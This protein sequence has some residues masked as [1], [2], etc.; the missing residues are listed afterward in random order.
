MDSKKVKTPRVVN[1]VDGGYSPKGEDKLVKVI[2][3]GHTPK[4]NTKVVGIPAN[5]ESE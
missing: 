4:H 3:G 2:D 5:V 1:I